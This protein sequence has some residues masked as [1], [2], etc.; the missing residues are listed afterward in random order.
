[1]QRFLDAQQH[2]EWTSFQQDVELVRYVFLTKARIQ[3]A[4]ALLQNGGVAPKQ[5]HAAFPIERQRCVRLS[6]VRPFQPLAA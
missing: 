1:M 4:E 2:A 3:R 6:I 5:L